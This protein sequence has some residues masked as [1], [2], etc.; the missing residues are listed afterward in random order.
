MS[1]SSGG[2]DCSSRYCASREGCI[3][4]SEGFDLFS[5]ESAELSDA[6]TYER[7]LTRKQATKK[8]IISVFNIAL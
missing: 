1:V 4:S 6:Y 5:L 2:C 8:Q 7:L 3:L